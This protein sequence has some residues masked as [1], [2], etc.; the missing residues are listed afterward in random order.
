MIAD[1]SEKAFISLRCTPLSI[2]A[3]TA[4]SRNMAIMVRTCCCGCDLRTG[5]LL[6]GIFGMVGIVASPFMPI[7]LQ[8][9]YVLAS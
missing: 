2:G 9:V 4:L 3:L 8:N 1:E 5:I 7:K 6:I